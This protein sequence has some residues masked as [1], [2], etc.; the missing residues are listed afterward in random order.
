MLGESAKHGLALVVEAHRWG[1]WGFVHM[2]Q[3]QLTPTC[4]VGRGQRHHPDCPNAQRTSGPS[5]PSG[6][7]SETRC[8]VTRSR[9]S[10]LRAL[11]RLPTE[12]TPNSIL[13][14]VIEHL[15]HPRT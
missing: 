15:E 3:C 5:G 10:R 1:S 6:L 9:L 12:L 2:T 13:D 8:N 7:T 4:T 14:A 11:L